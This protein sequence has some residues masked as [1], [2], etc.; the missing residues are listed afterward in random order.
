MMV[1][2]QSKL[3]AFQ[4]KNKKK[5]TTP[6]NQ[7]PLRASDLYDSVILCH[8]LSS[9]QSVPMAWNFTPTTI[10]TTTTASTQVFAIHADTQN[11]YITPWIG[12][13]FVVRFCPRPVFE[14]QLCLPTIASGISAAWIYCV[15]LLLLP[16]ARV[17]MTHGATHGP[18]LMTSLVSFVDSFKLSYFNPLHNW[19][20]HLMIGS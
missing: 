15:P 13:S 4:K 2:T 12:C 8:S 18:E 6:R 14:K 17:E 1:Q 11:L 16:F 19:L 9:I 7:P 10:C 5:N 3:T 20:L